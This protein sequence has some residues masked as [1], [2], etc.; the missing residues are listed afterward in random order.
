MVRKTSKKIPPSNY[1]SVAGEKMTPL[2]YIELA[3]QDPGFGDSRRDKLAVAALKFT[4]DP[5]TL[6]GMAKKKPRVKEL[7]EAA[8]HAVGA[9]GMFAPG[10]A[11]GMA[12]ANGTDDAEA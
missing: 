1:V 6:M 5:E 9:D 3:L 11:P 2:E 8:A 12:R 10:A 4:G 7:R